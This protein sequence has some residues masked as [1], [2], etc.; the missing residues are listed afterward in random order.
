MYKK[1]DT[2]P[3]PIKAKVV[4]ATDG[5]AITTGV[6][7][8][9]ITGSTR[10]AG[11]GTLTH[12]ANGLWTYTPTQT[13]TN[14][15]E[16]AIEFYHTSAVSSGPIVQVFTSSKLVSEL[17]DL[18]AADVNTEVDTALVDIGLDHLISTA[19]V[20][21]DVADNSIIAKIAS[22][23][24]TA[25]WDSFDNT[26][27]SLEAIRDNQQASAGTGA[28]TV[29]ITIDDG[30]NPIENVKVRVTSG[31]ETYAQT[32]DSSGQVVFYLDDA[33]WT[34]VITKAGYQGTSAS[35]AVSSDISQTYSITQIVAVAASD[36]GYS[37]VMALT[38][39]DALD[40]LIDVSGGDTSG[41]TKK[42]ALRAIHSSR[43]IIASYRDWSYFNAVLSVS[44][45][46]PY[47]TGT[48]SYDHT[49]GAYERQLTLS[50]GT[51]PSWA[52]RGT[53]VISN[54]FYQVEE[55]KSDSVLTLKETSNPGQD[56]SSGTSYKLV[57][58]AYLLPSDFIRADQLRNVNV[59]GYN[60]KYVPP[61]RLIRDRISRE[62]SNIPREYTIMRDPW[63]PGRLALFLYPPPTQ[64]YVYEFTYQRQPKPLKTLDYSTGTVTLTAGSQAVTGSGTSWTSAME[65]SILRVSSDSSNVP[66]NL[67]GLN[68][69][70]EQYEILWVNS[71]TSLTLKVQAA[72]SRSGVA[73]RISDPID[74]EIGP[75][76]DAFLS[77]CEWWWAKFTSASAEDIA[78][79]QA[80]Y[81]EML[82]TAMQHDSVNDKI[83]TNPGAR[84]LWELGTVE[85][86]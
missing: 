15:D 85:L 17:N 23:L 27:D 79:K 80:A 68:P 54:G 67:D 3:K 47:S 10:T 70:E 59:D 41:R 82:R 50:G 24:S 46:A 49:G 84:N 28:R 11:G 56:I 29:T 69:Y 38:Y 18:A 40:W 61:D 20:G 9:H 4:S 30:T 53:V 35:L 45:Q 5:S 6:A 2:S 48:I 39:K 19:V 51:W 26:S 8:Y 72:E 31:A 1:N 34:V 66:D 42:L 75:M 22:K 86:S 33:T 76:R 57:Q 73:Y 7:A 58:E 71:A 37:D 13:E 32:T 77:C 83:D 36:Y 43:R 81:V 14:Y 63:Q 16:F 62:S 64:L 55:R 44:T 52:E 78:K 74:L 65:G 60:P 21:A 12:V 25:D